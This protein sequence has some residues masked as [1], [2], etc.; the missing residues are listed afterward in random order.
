MAD[1][2]QITNSEA[3]TERDRQEEST[4]EIKTNITA[5]PDVSN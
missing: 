5:G 2:K 3:T 4:P 1:N